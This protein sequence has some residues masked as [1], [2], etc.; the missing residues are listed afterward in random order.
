MMVLPLPVM[1][2]ASKTPPLS[3][4]S[5][6]LSSRSSGSLTHPMKPCDP[7]ISP[8][9]LL[10]CGAP[11]T[12]SAHSC[13]Y[14]DATASLSTSCRPLFAPTGPKVAA[15]HY[16]VSKAVHRE[17]AHMPKAGGSRSLTAWCC[18]MG[19][20]PPKLASSCSGSASLRASRSSAL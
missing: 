20:R 5:R 12:H 2:T 16:Y 1:K 8:L 13:I 7:P 19:G 4:C 14:Q 11:D 17:G 18:A 9:T 6:R 15:E 10:L 3:S